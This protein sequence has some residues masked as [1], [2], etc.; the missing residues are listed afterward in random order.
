MARKSKSTGSK[1]TTETVRDLVHEILNFQCDTIDQV[2]VQTA[3][4]ESNELTKAQAVSVSE[5]MKSA[6]RDAA[7][8]VL[9]SKA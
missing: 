3:N 2:L 6:T 1:W 7:F 5:V 4:N 9:S 8:R